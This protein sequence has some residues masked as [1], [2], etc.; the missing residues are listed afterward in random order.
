M[1]GLPGPCRARGP[2][3]LTHISEPGEDKLLH[4]RSRDL[5]VLGIAAMVVAADQITKA[6]VRRSLLLGI[7]W[8]PVPWLRPILSFTY[9][10]NI[11]AAFG[12]FPQ[13]SAVY[14]LIAVT[15]LGVL[16]FFFRHLVASGWPA[17]IGLGL[18]LGGVLG[19]N[20]IDRL[21]HGYVT[22]FIDLN[23]WPLHEW[24]VFNIAD[25]SV[26]VGVC[27]LSIYL[28]LQE[29]PRAP[30]SAGLGTSTAANAEP[31]GDASAAA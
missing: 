5:V 13:L 1:Y 12:I 31:D 7:P 8:D 11:G 2:P 23:F 28:L 29:E 19:N 9:V 15:V 16:F 14:P 22:D 6:W 25:S 10:T 3:T 21:W 24:P 20:I 27:V 17:T 4:G 18:L 26:V 30:A